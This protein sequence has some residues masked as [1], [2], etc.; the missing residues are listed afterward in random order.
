MVYNNST[1]MLIFVLF[2]LQSVASE[3]ETGSWWPWSKKDPLPAETRTTAELTKLGI[4]NTELGLLS[5]QYRSRTPDASAIQTHRTDLAAHGVELGSIVIFGQELSSGKWTHERFG[6][7]SLD[8]KIDGQKA[9]IAAISGTLTTKDTLATVGTLIGRTTSYDFGRGLEAADADKKMGLSI[10]SGY[11][12][13]YLELGPEVKTIAPD[14]TTTPSTSGTSFGDFLAAKIKQNPGIPVWIVGHS[15]G[16]IVATIAAADMLPLCT[17]QHNPMT[18]LTIGSPRGWGRRSAE[19]VNLKLN[20]GGN[21]CYRFA[22]NNDMVPA[23][24]WNWAGRK[25]VGRAEKIFRNAGNHHILHYHRDAAKAQLITNVPEQ[26]G[27]KAY[28][29]AFKE[30]EQS[31]SQTF[32]EECKQPFIPGTKGKASK[33]KC[34]NQFGNAFFCMGESATR[35]EHRNSCCCAFGFKFDATTKKCVACTATVIAE[36]ARLQDEE[37]DDSDEL[38]VGQSQYPEFLKA[39]QAI[40]MFMAGLL[41]AFVGSRVHSFCLQRQKKP[42]EYALLKA[43]AQEV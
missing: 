43:D 22:F 15:L 14:G 31:R 6:Y 26:H 23:L 25:H 18:V 2:M 5:N 35:Q 21:I 1:K 37:S 30:L 28:L 38:E 17:K 3:T 39:H 34:P 36:D 42:A 16:G 32:A 8:S 24:V 33:R 4:I 9:I 12:N 27:Q 13:H 11:L 7:V 40:G 10:S 41:T 20:S 19:K 29:A